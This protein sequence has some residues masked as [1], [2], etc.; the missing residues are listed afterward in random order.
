MKPS[1][2]RW[3][4]C[5]AVLLAGCGADTETQRQLLSRLDASERS[6]QALKG[7]LEALR[8]D[9]E[10]LTDRSVARI[11]PG[12]EGYAALAFDLG[13]LLVNVGEVRAQGSGSKL[14]LN[15]GNLTAAKIDGLF[16]VLEWGTIDS[17]GYPN[18]YHRESREVVFD[19]V[20][21]SGAWTAS[22]IVLEGVPPSKVGY[23]R[24]RAVRQRAVVLD[25]KRP[26]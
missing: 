24:L 11:R 2:T 5:A 21:P 18:E 17:I 16:A 14:T 10:R 6:N 9:V 20:L 22:A 15:F 26:G 12:D 8:L 25:A 3:L 13:T 23:L 19:T 1:P 4:L 7:R